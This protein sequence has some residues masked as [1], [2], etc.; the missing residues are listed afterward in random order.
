MSS[1]SDLSPAIAAWLE[2]INDGWVKTMNV[3]FKTVT[4]QEVI[5]ELTI[6]SQHRQ[7]LGLVH[8]GVHAGLIETVASVGAS[9]AVFERG[10]FAVGLENH[11][12]FLHAAREGRLRAV[13]KPLQAG[14]QTHIWEVNI[15]DQN[16]RLVASGRVRLMIIESGRPL[17]GRSAAFEPSVG[18]PPKTS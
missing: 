6:G 15:F 14:R 17:A 16:Q 8:G 1:S 7:P 4:P 10:C 11:T 5:A 13:G 9:V 3:E 2:A 12:S 18:E